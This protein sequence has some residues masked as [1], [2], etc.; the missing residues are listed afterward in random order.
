MLRRSMTFGPGNRSIGR[1]RVVGAATT[2]CVV[3]AVLMIFADGANAQSGDAERVGPVY[4]PTSKSYF[5]IR[6]Y[7]HIKPPG[8][9][10]ANINKHV[11]QLTF[12]GVQ[13]RL[14]IIRS[15][16]T[17]QFVQGNVL[18][19][20]NGYV[21]AVWIGLRLFCRG[22]KQ[23]WVDG[24]VR[25]KGDFA[26]WSRRWYRNETATCMNQNFQYMPVYYGR[27]GSSWRWQASG[28]IKNFAHVLMEY[29]TGEE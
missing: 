29:P 26:A 2:V 24:H 17:H 8:R 13:G 1:R 11:K 19:D 21:E 15:P 10:W 9:N 18:K 3:I 28:Q 27:K 16:E 4:D 14:A 25:R 6:D 20:A 7:S 12:K 5:E 23:L 22:M